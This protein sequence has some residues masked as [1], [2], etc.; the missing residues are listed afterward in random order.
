MRQKLV[1]LFFFAFITSSIL[2]QQTRVSFKVVNNKSEGFPFVTV[3]VVSVPDTINKVERI[4][5]ST[6]F[7]YF[8]LIAGRPYKIIVSAV[9]FVPVVKAITVKGDNPVYTI[10]VETL[11]TSLGTVVVNSRR[12]IM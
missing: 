11:S 7:A 6:G 4:T 3:C 2:V 5:D 12:P 9:E 1:L 8:S 10:V